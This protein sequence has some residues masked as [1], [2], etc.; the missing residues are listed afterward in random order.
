MS[1]PR[2][3]I[4]SWILLL[5]LT[6]PALPAVACNTSRSDLP[7][8]STVTVLPTRPSV[9]TARQKTSAVEPTV[10][11]TLTPPAQTAVMAET[12]SNQPNS[13]TRSLPIP[14]RSPAASLGLASTPVRSA[15]PTPVVVQSASF[16]TPSPVPTV[17]PTERPPFQR[18][19]AN[20]AADDD[21]IVGAHYYPWYSGCITANLKWGSGSWNVPLTIVDG[22]QLQR[23]RRERTSYRA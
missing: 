5:A 11:P 17:T 22:G 21:L 2:T 19:F 18:V 4:M 20:S 12:T 7:G 23:Q 10:P 15:T 6:A 8:Q 9:E 1:I 16:P 13:P 14:S 3:L